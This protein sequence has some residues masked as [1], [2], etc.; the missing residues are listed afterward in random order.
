MAFADPSILRWSWASTQPYTEDDARAY[1]AHQSRQRARGR[2]VS[3]AFTPPGEPGQVLG[4]GSVYDIDP[5]HRRASVGYRVVPEARGRG[6]AT[7]ATRL[8][9]GWASEALGVQRLQITC[10]PDNVASQRVAERCGYTR[11]A[12]L[13]SHMSFQGTRR[14]TVM[15]SR[16]AGPRDDGSPKAAAQVAGARRIR[17][18]P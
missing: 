9:S 14:D 2:A 18:L 17:P 12:L 7:H 6:V 13:R 15:F 1:F 16:L 11:E 4:G 3:L 8:M 5:D 10:A